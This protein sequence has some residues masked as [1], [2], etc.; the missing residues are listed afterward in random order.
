MPA[1]LHRVVT[2][3]VRILY[4]T[5]KQK[6]KELLRASNSHGIFD[7]LGPHG[8]W[9]RMF[10]CVVKMV[11][12]NLQDCHSRYILKFRTVYCRSLG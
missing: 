4:I 3:D 8:R 10:A 6:I 9:N 5:V 1:L 2:G 11:T 7:S 12:R